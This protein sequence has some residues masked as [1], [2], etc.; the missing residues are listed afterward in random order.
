MRSL[1]RDRTQIH[2]NFTGDKRRE[3]LAD[4]YRAAANDLLDDQATKKRVFGSA[5]WKKI[6]DQLGIETHGK[7][8]FCETPTDA[9]YWGD[10]EH[11]RPKSVHWWLAYCYDNF[12]YSCAPCNGAKS[13]NFEP[14]GVSLP[15]PELAVDL[16]EE[17]LW[18][19]A[20]TFVPD[21]MNAIAVTEY[22]QDC[23]AE[24]SSLPN[25]YHENVEDL[26]A[27]QVIPEVEEVVI[28]PVGQDSRSGVATEAAIRLVKLN[29]PELRTQRYGVYD[30]IERLRH[31][32]NSVDPNAVEIG[33]EL[34]EMASAPYSPYSAMVRYFLQ[35]WK[36]SA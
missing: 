5:R 8:G 19:I 30:R 15:A 25:P 29:R 34:L 11:F 26:F 6:K 3:H 7:C 36:L 12:L 16:D 32:L 14:L 4:L 24:K 1:E 23:L 2:E 17:E 18:E 33:K 31:L 28:I 10:V 21:P 27:W 20:Q 22:K 35:Q 9:S 13:N